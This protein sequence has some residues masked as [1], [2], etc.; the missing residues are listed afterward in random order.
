M[1]RSVSLDLVPGTYRARIAARQG[2][3]AGTSPAVEATRVRR[4]LLVACALA[5]VWPAAATAGRYAVGV[6]EGASLNELA[7]Q[8]ESTTGAEVTSGD[9]ALRALFVESET[10][11]GARSPAR[12]PLRRAR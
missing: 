12:G 5:L 11:S 8:I 2:F 6:E 9:V 1:A 3:A 10:A 7:A 4:A